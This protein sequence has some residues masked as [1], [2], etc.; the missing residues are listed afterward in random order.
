MGK[1]RILDN[2]YT[3]GVIFSGGTSLVD[4]RSTDDN[5]YRRIDRIM[6]NTWKYL[7]E[8]FISRDLSTDLSYS[9][10]LTEV[11]DGTEQSSVFM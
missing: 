3:N 1:R 7:V 4:E 2:G 10:R 5:C 11:R 8:T 9:R 6:V